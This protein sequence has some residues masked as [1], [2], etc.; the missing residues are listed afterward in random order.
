MMVVKLDGSDEIEEEVEEEEGG[1]MR[2]R[3]EPDHNIY[4]GIFIYK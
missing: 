1:G 2:K 4:R 3:D